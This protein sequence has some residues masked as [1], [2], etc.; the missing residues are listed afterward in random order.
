MFKLLGNMV[1]GGPIL[2]DRKYSTYCLIIENGA[3]LSK[4]VAD[5]RF[6]SVKEISGCNSVLLIKNKTKI[7]LKSPIGIGASILQFAK[8]AMYLYWYFFI[9]PA[10]GI[11]NDLKMTYLTK[12]KVHNPDIMNIIE[13][14]RKFIKQ[15]WLVYTDTDS[16]CFAF[17]TTPEGTSKTLEWFHDNTILGTYLDK[18]NYNVLPKD[19]SHENAPGYFKSEISD[20]ILDTAIFA[21]LKLYFMRSFNRASLTENE[22]TYVLKRAHRCSPAFDIQ[23]M[24]FEEDYHSLLDNPDYVSCDIVSTRIHRDI[25]GGISTVVSRKLALNLHENKRFYISATVS[26]AYGHPDIPPSSKTEILTLKGGS[27]IK[28]TFDKIQPFRPSVP[29]VV[30]VEHSII[31]SGSPTPAAAAASVSAT[32]EPDIIDET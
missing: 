25:G 4:H 10:C 19:L 11:Y 20:N 29:N 2:N 15:I 1:Y 28:G 24:L 26:L 16:I 23:K 21:S 27:Y 5:P 17:T 30:G 7:I 8:V 3:R 13:K 18:S 22:P 12:Y 31:T 32:T 14:S 6:R 9:K